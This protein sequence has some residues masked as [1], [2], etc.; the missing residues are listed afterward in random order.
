L[1]KT[2]SSTPAVRETLQFSKAKLTDFGELPTGEI[3]QALHY[4]FAS[5]LSTLSNGLRV[6]TEEMDSSMAT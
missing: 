6:V 2:G 5:Q 1:T 4:D 3:P